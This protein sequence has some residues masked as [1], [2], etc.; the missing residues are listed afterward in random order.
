MLLALGLFAFGI[1]TLAH[2]ELQ[3]RSSWRHATSPRIGARDATQFVGA[4]EET[5]A[6]A[7]TAYAEL[8][9]GRA[10]LDELRAMANSGDAWP[11]VDGAGRVFGAYVIQ[12]IDEGQS[13]LLADGTPLK[14][15]FTINLLRV[16]DEARA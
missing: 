11:L 15:D 3:R 9:D 12:T 7:G 5:I 1:P 16:D 14:I 4:G 6:I 8:S 10:S 2:D 13:V